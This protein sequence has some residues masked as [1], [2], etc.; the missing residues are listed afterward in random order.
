MT[1]KATDPAISE[2]PLE[3]GERITLPI[4]RSVPTE[5][6]EEYTRLRGERPVCPVTLRTGEPA[7]L[8]T[9][10][11]DL[12]TVLTDRRFSRAAVCDDDAQKTGAVRPN[13]DTIINM[14]PPR[15]A[16]I[17][18]LAAEAFTQERMGK[19]RPRIERIVEE[20]V[21][22][23]ASM[24]P[25]VDLI[26]AFARPLPLRIICEMLGVPFA[27][28]DRI[29]G[30]VEVIMT[31]TST[32]EGVIGA[33]VEMRGY[34]AEL[35]ESKRQNLGEGFLSALAPWSDEGDRLTESELISLGTF[36]LVAG[37]ETSV[38]VIT[39]AVL[40]LIRHPDQ[41]AD[42]LADKSLLD[43]AVEGMLRVGIPGVSPFPRIA[44]TDI[45]LRDEVI[46]QGTAV[47]VNYETALRDPEVFGSG[48]EAD[49]EAFDIRRKP[50]SQVFFGPGPHFCLGAPVARMELEYGI[51]GL[52]RR[53]PG[54][55]L[56][57]PAEE[58]KWK[59]F[60]ALGNYEEFPVTW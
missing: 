42:L 48:A 54:L 32:S 4:P 50:L 28:R 6:A 23:V 31:I 46:P 13:P 45:A 56:A 2:H 17:R 9:R 58:L 57:I 33:Y 38:T 29:V 47:V 43:G 53:F 51:W 39:D 49:P 22:E 21:E 11:D 35:V 41:L 30:W 3:E 24:T 60:A 18:K 52:F 5:V 15:H 55:R 12:K 8:V 40:Q 44:T 59:D 36:L 16:R 19:L 10:H 27:D 34:F 25:P 20:L 1:D 26:G 7:L 14:D 37:H